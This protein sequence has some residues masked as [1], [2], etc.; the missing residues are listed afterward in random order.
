MAKYKCPEGDWEQDEP[1]MCPNH[2]E[3]ELV[4]A[5]EEGEMKEEGVEE[6]GEGET[7]E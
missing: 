1:G 2:P 6:S 4:M 3:K 5:E 7:E